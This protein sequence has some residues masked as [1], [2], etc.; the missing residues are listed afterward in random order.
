VKLWQDEPLKKEKKI[1]ETDR[2]KAGLAIPLSKI[3]ALNN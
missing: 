3:Y 2:K 1:E